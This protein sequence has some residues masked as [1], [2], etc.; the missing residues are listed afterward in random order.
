MYT[1]PPHQK[2]KACHGENNMGMKYGSINGT[3]CRA[4]VAQSASAFGC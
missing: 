4:S 1:S 2:R 3:P